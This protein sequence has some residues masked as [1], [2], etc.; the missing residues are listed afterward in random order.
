MLYEFK[1]YNVC[2]DLSTCCE[3]ITTV[4]LVNIF[5]RSHHLCVRGENS[6]SNFQLY[7]TLLLNSHHFVH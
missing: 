1:V 3:M 4:R 2:D 5:I 7:N 6:P